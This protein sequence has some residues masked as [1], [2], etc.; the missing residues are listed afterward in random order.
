[1]KAKRVEERYS[2]AVS[3]ASTLDGVGGQ[4]HIP[5][6]LHPG[7]K[8]GTSFTGGCESAEGRSGRMRMVPISIKYEEVLDYLCNFS[9]TDFSH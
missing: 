4:R 7:K 1:M 8:H 6:A 2:S 5:S 9:C 3:V